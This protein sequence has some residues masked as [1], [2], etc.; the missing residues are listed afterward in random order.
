MSKGGVTAA[1]RLIDRRKSALQGIDE[2]IQ[3]ASVEQRLDPALVKAIIQVESAWNTRAR[4]QKGALGLM[5]LMPETSRRF[6]VRDPYDPRENI[7]GG[8]RY[9]RSLLNRFHENLRYSLA[10][11]NAGEKAVA[12]WGDVPPFAE[13]R[14]YLQR[15]SMIYAAR[16]QQAR[17]AETAISR[18]VQGNRVIYANVD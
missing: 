9:L 3:Q 1:L 17:L 14:T 18:T 8:T 15:I 11:Y 12:S 5:Q 13:T 2:F 4:S 6:G 7:R 10:A 16:E